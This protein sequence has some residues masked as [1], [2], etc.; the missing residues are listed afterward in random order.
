MRVLLAVVAAFIVAAA[1]VPIYFVLIQPP[2][3]SPCG[4]NSGGSPP[5]VVVL[6]AP[7]FGLEYMNTTNVGST[8]WYNFSVIPVPA[9]LN[10]GQLTLRVLLPNGSAMIGVDQYLVWNGAGH[11]VAIA[12]GSTSAWTEGSS[13]PLQSADTVT[14]VSSTSL[15]GYYLEGT[16]PLEC[17]QTSTSLSPFG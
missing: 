8:F 12:N 6:G 1:A 17:G 9:N 14:V 16:V 4:S 3:S 10:V 13:S 5:L 2:S 15:A 11:L 7:P